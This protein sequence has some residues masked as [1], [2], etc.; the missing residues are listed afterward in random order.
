MASHGNAPS[1]AG[2]CWVNG[3]G[4]FL[5]TGIIGLLLAGTAVMGMGSLF[6]TDG[7]DKAAT[8]PRDT[9]GEDDD[10]PEQDRSEAERPNLIT[11]AFDSTQA[12]DPLPV[13]AT[14]AGTEAE[15]GLPEMSFPSPV[16][17]ADAAL[18]HPDDTE[19]LTLDG[20][21]GDDLRAGAAGNDVIA[22]DAGND[23]L[24]GRAGDDLLSGD[25][26]DDEVHGAEGQDTLLGGAGQDTLYGGTGNDR[27][28]GDDGD[29]LL[30]GQ[31]GDDTLDGG[32]GDDSLHGGPGDDVV[33]G[34]AGDDALHGGL[35]DDT[36]IG[37]AGADT[38]FGGAGNDLL[39]GTLQGDLSQATGDFLNGGDGADTIIAG[40]GDVVTSGRGPDVLMLG[41]WITSPVHVVD[42]D[43]SEDSLIVLFDDTANPDPHIMLRPDDSIPDRINIFLDGQHVAS[44]SGADGLTLSDINLMP[45]SQVLP[46]LPAPGA[47]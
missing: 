24:G 46:F 23:R 32:P 39:L 12:D 25:A 7:A 4:M 10:I 18:P 40:D 16:T 5:L 27:L 37:G 13:S 17:G 42:F 3:C 30:F 20:T 1:G 41:D 35:G 28:S 2:G 29:D 14:L 21:E 6:D 26:G 31:A 8:G 47:A 44:L 22:G 43:Q 36:L 34:G 15:T 9:G 45:Q 11:A 19:P 33:I 38:L